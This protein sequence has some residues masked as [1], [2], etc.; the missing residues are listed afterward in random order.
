MAILSACDDC[1]KEFNLQIKLRKHM[2]SAHANQKDLKPIDYLDEEID[3]AMFKGGPAMFRGG[4]VMFR[5]GP[6]KCRVGPAMFS[7]GPAMFSGGP[8]GYMVV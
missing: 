4:P 3:P 6:A 7:G 8:A 5:G 2:Q 1:G